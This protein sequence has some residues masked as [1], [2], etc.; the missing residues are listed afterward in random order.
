ML[1]TQYE[2]LPEPNE[3]KSNQMLSLLY[4]SQKRRHPH[5]D[6]KASA[7]IPHWFL[8]FIFVEYLSTESGADD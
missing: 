8:F 7:D 3:S 5:Y 4:S 1:P 6:N 2:I